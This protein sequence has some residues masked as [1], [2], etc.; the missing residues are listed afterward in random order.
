MRRIPPI[1]SRV[2][3]LRALDLLNL[4]IADAQTGFGA[5]LAVYLASH[6]WTELQIGAVLSIG[7][8]ATIV[9]QIP[10]GALVDAAR[11]KRAALAGGIGAIT[12]SALL[13]ALL[14]YQL[15]VAVAE[16]LHGFASCVLTPAVA[17]VSLR[18]VGHAGLPE[19]LGRNARYAAIGNGAAAAVMGAIGTYVSTRSVFLLTAALAAPALFALH[20]IGKEPASA[21]CPGAAR[22]RTGFDWRGLGQLLADRRLLAFGACVVLFHMANAAMLPLAAGTITAKA[23]AYASLIIAAC[24][25]VPQAVVAVSS[26]LVGR[27]AMLWGRRTVLLVGWSALPV[28]AALFAIL[29]APALIV[30]AQALDGISAAVFGVMVPLIAA[31]LTRGRGRFN[32]CIGIFGLATGIGATIS[33]SLAGWIA[34]AVGDRMAF[35]ALAGIGMA[36]VALLAL[37]MPETAPVEP[38]AATRPLGSIQPAGSTPLR[39]AQR[40]VARHPGL[41]ADRRRGYARAVRGGGEW[42]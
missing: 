9:S 21:A 42:R 24:I 26:P 17:A 13:L 30:T 41:R 7:T 31:D 33:T 3:G 10:A 6:K 5:F 18:L 29:P 25:V 8:V 23:G 38:T 16:I 14:P 4:F 28:R 40:M 35:A 15:P 27:R 34:D 37:A 32:L 19:R 11:S 20:R 1:L 39:P 2:R 12:L 22:R 36:G